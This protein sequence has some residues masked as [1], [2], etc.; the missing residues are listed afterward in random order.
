MGDRRRM[1]CSLPLFLLVVVLSPV[2]FSQKIDILC[3]LE[4]CGVQMYECVTNTTCRDAL[5]CFGGCGT[6]LTCTMQCLYSYGY[7][8]PQFT[9]FFTCAT[10]QHT[11]MTTA[12]SS[13]NCTKPENLAKNFTFNMLKGQWYSVRGMTPPTDCYDCS[14]FLYET[15]QHGFAMRNTFDADVVNGKAP[16]PLDGYRAALSLLLDRIS[17]S[18]AFTLDIS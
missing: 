14:S 7:E 2:V 16:F 1:H 6:N 5:T 13:F 10:V 12:P 18:F 9:K 8:D 17:V 11:C 15:Y 3:L 4:H